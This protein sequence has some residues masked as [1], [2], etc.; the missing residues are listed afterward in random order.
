VSQPGFFEVMFSGRHSLTPSEVDG[1]YFVDRSGDDFEHILRFLRDGAHPALQALDDGT[2]QRVVYEADFYGLHE[3]VDILLCRGYLRHLSADDHEMKLAEDKLRHV[4]NPGCFPAPPEPL[5]ASDW[6]PK[7]YD[8]LVEIFRAKGSSVR[9]TGLTGRRA[10][11]NGRIGVIKLYLETTSD[12]E[13]SLVDNGLSSGVSQVVVNVDGED[14]YFHILN[15]ESAHEVGCPPL[16]STFWRTADA[17]TYPTLLSAFAEHHRRDVPGDRVLVSTQLEFEQ[18]F[19]AL[20]PGILERLRSVK[21][22]KNSGWFAAGGAIFLAMMRRP[23]RASM[24]TNSHDQ[25]DLDIFIHAKT[26]KGATKI[27]R[28][29]FDALAV[30]GEGWIISRGAYVINLLRSTV[31]DP[32]LPNGLVFGTPA[33]PVQ[34]VLRRYQS[35]SEVLLGFDVDCCAFGFDGVRVYATPRALRAVQRGCNL[36]NPI[37]AWNANPIYEF[38]LAKYATRGMCVAVPGLALDQVDMVRLTA[39]PLAELQGLARLLHMHAVLE[40]EL[41][42]RVLAEPNNEGH[43]PSL[44]KIFGRIKYFSGYGG[45]VA[46]WNAPR[47]LPADEMD[48]QALNSPWFQVTTEPHTATEDNPNSS[49]WV[50]IVACRELADEEEEADQAALWR[51]MLPIMSAEQRERHWAVILDAGRDNLRI[52]RVLKWAAGPLPGLIATIESAC[53]EPERLYFEAAFKSAQQI[54][55]VQP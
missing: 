7:P 43:L 51:G 49:A 9:L 8:G 30:D 21:T 1:T 11:L 16:P 54:T 25:T 26:D 19:E 48:A 13:L 31:R 35:P 15:V 27:A 29:L 33:R 46:T 23:S 38:R 53:G 34:I 39:T 2:K 40:L 47:A 3:L 12:D 50:L 28:R 36:L 20:F 44:R 14:S 5:S 41:N 32:P 24:T 22:T 10:P 17:L 45:E 42:R 4:W 6:Q 18:K 52:S 55:P 37:H